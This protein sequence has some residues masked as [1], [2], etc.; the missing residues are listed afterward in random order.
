M[1]FWNQIPY[2]EVV[3]KSPNEMAAQ[4]A[5]RVLRTYD[6]PLVAGLTWDYRERIRRAWL[7]YSSI[8]TAL[9]VNYL[10]RRNPHFLPAPDDDESVPYLYAQSLVHSEMIGE[11]MS[12]PARRS[13][14]SFVTPPALG[15]RM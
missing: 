12:S 7:G 15:W 13:S 2:Q 4:D 5:S 6:F 1:S 14:L 8:Q 9:G 3:P 10:S 11:P